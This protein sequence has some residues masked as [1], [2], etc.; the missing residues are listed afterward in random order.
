MKIEIISNAVILRTSLPMYSGMP[1]AG[2][3]APRRQPR[4]YAPV[5]AKKVIPGYLTTCHGYFPPQQCCV[6]LYYHLGD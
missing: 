5:N 6:F 3:I 2:F 1:H 4:R